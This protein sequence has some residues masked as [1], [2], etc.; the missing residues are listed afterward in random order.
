MNEQHIYH[1][2]ASEAPR[3]NVKIEKNTKGYNWEVTVTGA[4]TVAAALV[5]INEA[6]T[7]LRAQYGE[8]TAV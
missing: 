8:K 5:L 6:E 3:V 7:A 2:N 4:P 1:H